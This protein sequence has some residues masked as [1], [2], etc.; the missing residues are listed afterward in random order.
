MWIRDGSK[1][2]GGG[3]RRRKTQAPET[4][5]GG[6]WAVP[7]SQV[8]DLAVINK[9]LMQGLRDCRSDLVKAASYDEG[10]PWEVL[11]ALAI[12]DILISKF[13]ECH[14]PS[15]LACSGSPLGVVVRGGVSDR[16]NS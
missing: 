5:E 7:E 2:G 12:C 9:E 3:Y 10:V 11:D 15:R 4:E 14:G 1:G 13:G 8:V 16:S 6:F